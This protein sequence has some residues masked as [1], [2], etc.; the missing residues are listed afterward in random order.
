[1]NK[2]RLSLSCLKIISCFLG[3]ALCFSLY[4]VLPAAA[5]IC[6]LRNV[7]PSLITVP[8]SIDGKDRDLGV[9]QSYQFAAA[10]SNADSSA[11]NEIKAIERTAII[12]P[13]FTDVY[14][15]FVRRRVRPKDS[16]DIVKTDKWQTAMNADG[17]LVGAFFIYY[18]DHKCLPLHF[19]QPVTRPGVEKEPESYLASEGTA[20]AH[21][22]FFPKVE[23]DSFYV[24]MVT[25]YKNK[26]KKDKFFLERLYKEPLEGFLEAG[27]FVPF[28]NTMVSGLDREK[29]VL[30]GFGVVD[31]RFS[32]NQYGQIQLDILSQ[33]Q[34][35]P[36]RACQLNDEIERKMQQ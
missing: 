8:V 27:A 20:V 19:F 30:Q 12:F 16:C 1:M 4:P 2:R 10:D 22:A 9:L 14:K 28:V 25:S 32:Q 5:Q 13:D 3:V 23:G 29:D 33:Q 21:N 26:G 36:E 31:M 7:G 18:E 6:Q 24:E 34:V 35:S 17:T 11:S 15:L